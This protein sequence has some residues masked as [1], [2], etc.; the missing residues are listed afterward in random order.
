MEG[1]ERF[2]ITIERSACP[3]EL[4]CMISADMEKIGE[5]ECADVTEFCADMYWRMQDWVHTQPDDIIETSAFGVSVLLG[6]GDRGQTTKTGT[7]QAVRCDRERLAARLIMYR[8]KARKGRRRRVLQ[9]PLPTYYAVWNH[10][11]RER[12][13]DPGPPHVLRHVAPSFDLIEQSPARG[14]LGGF[15]SGAS[16]SSTSQSSPSVSGSVSDD[17]SRVAGTGESGGGD[18]TPY[19]PGGAYRTL[20]QVQDRGRWAASKSVQRYAK[21]SIYLRSL[22]ELPEWV[23]PLGA[24]RMRKM[25]PRSLIAK[26]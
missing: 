22:T 9:T 6:R 8:D 11:C 17:V 16:S 19:R 26:N 13:L 23:F 15:S 18:V 2:A 3:W 20:Q 14:P 1:W 12:G 24:D 7:N 25:G 21:T 4:V 5:P 10:V